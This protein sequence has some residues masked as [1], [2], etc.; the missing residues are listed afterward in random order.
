[1]N[2]EEWLSRANIKII[3][4]KVLRQAEKEVIQRDKP[5]SLKKFKKLNKNLHRVLKLTFTQ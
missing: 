1:M 5:N 4:G 3:A 2:P